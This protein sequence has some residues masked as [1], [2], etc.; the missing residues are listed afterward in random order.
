M[1]DTVLVD[2]VKR[3]ELVRE[4]TFC[5]TNVAVTGLM[6]TVDDKIPE[7]YLD[8]S[9]VIYVCASVMLVFLFDL[10][11][12]LAFKVTAAKTLHSTYQNVSQ[13]ALLGVP[14]H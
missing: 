1:L 8:K 2:L 9:I 12:S 13:D 4:W 10:P 7:V 5:N 6:G 11:T 14:R 3:Y